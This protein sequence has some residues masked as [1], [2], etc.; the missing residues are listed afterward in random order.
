MELRKH[1]SLCKPAAA[2]AVDSKDTY[3]APNRGE[4]WFIAIAN[5][6]GRLR[7]GALIDV[8]WARV[9]SAAPVYETGYNGHLQFP[10]LTQAI[11]CVNVPGS[12][13]RA[14][15]SRCYSA[16]F[17]TF[18][19]NSQIAISENSTR[20]RRLSPNTSPF[21]CQWHSCTYQ[22]LN[23]IAYVKCRLD[24]RRSFVFVS[25]ILEYPSGM[26]VLPVALFNLRAAERRGLSTPEIGLKF[27]GVEFGTI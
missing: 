13:P 16:A 18:G 24:P 2:D 10:V 8:S 14:A 5:L 12:D 7:G 22:L 15:N 21:K 6:K 27:S 25:Q 1:P 4:C 9:C 23:I 26:L 17:F 20:T 3:D 11:R 19:H